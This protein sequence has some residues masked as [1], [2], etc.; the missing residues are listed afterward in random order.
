MTRRTG[1]RE[2]VEQ[3]QTALESC[4]KDHRKVAETEPQWAEDTK[5]MTPEDLEE[6]SGCGCEDC[7][8][9]GELLG[10]I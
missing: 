8:R 2:S 4:L 9:A 6:L 7:K 5:G 10:S 3:L 1:N